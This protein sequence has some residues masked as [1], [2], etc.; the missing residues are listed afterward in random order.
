MK[1]GWA[2]MEGEGKGAVGFNGT[3]EDVSEEET[4]IESEWRIKKRRKK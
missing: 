3:N 2:R 4:V 1:D